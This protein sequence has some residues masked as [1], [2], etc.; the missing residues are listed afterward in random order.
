MR[1][2]DTGCRR[3]RSKWWIAVVVAVATVAGSIAVAVLFGPP[4]KPAPDRRPG[5]GCESS[6]DCP[7]HAVCAARGCLILLPSEFQTMWEEDVAAQRDP[8]A[9]WKPPSFFGEKLLPA[10]VCPAPAGTVAPPDENH[11]QILTKTTVF[12]FGGDEPAVHRQLRTRGTMWFESVRFWMPAGFGEARD[13]GTVCVSSGVLAAATGRG[14]WRGREAAYV[15]VSLP[16]AIP[17]GQEARAAVSMPLEQLPADGQGYRTL[18]LALDPVFDGA[19][20]RT[21]VALPLGTDVAALDGVLPA[22]QRLLTGYVAYVWE[23]GDAPGK[24]AV[25]FRLPANL[26]RRLDIRELNP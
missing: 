21:A 16:Q 5:S 15:D 11:L 7:A 26:D 25:R 24:A 17:V 4:E 20:E 1:N 14:K 12:D 10:D 8:A 18:E 2:N 19:V 9:R 23:H 13:Q 22:R 3:S 6:A